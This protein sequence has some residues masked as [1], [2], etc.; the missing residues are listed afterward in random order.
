MPSYTAKRDD[1]TEV[2]VEFEVEQHGSP[3]NMWDDPGEPTLVAITAAE[4]GDKAVTL[5]DDERERIEQ[6]VGAWIDEN[7]SD[8][9][10]DEY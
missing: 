3:G 4:A 7:P 9:Y 6:E 10:G 2:E 8:F 1:G 5:T